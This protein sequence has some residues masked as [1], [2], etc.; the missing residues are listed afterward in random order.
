MMVMVPYPFAAE[1]HQTANAM[2]LVNHHAAIMVKDDEAK[3]KLISEVMALSFD[4]NRKHELK[5]NIAKM[6]VSDAD[7]RIAKEIL[8]A[9][10]QQ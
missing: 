10:R 2:N 9:N 8:S 6:G 3:Q 7:Q 1:D 5:A 4:E